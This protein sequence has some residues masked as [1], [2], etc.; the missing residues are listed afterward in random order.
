M[1]PDRLANICKNN[2]HCSKTPTGRPKKD[3]LL[4][5][6]RSN[7]SQTKKK[8]K[9]ILEKYNNNIHGYITFTTIIH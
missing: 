3:N 4:T 8:K 6:N 2:K 7:S 9:Y 5:T 1:A